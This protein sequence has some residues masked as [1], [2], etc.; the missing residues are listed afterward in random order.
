[1]VIISGMIFLAI[2]TPFIAAISFQKHRPTFGDSGRIAYAA[3]ISNLEF[4]FPGDGGDFY[5]DGIG[6][7]EN[8]ANYSAFSK[9]L[10]HPV[11][12]VFDDPAAYSFG[13]HTA[14]THPFWFD[15]SYWQEGVRPAFNLSRQLQV[16]GYAIA[17]LLVLT[18]GLFYQL[19]VTVILLLLF[20]LAP[21]PSTCLAAA[22]E[23][24][25]LLAP[26][27]I[28]ILMYA[29]VHLEYR[30]I[31]PF[32]CVG[33][34]VLFSGVR[35][36]FSNNLR[37]VMRFAVFFAA[38]SQ[39]VLAG[40]TTYNVLNRARHY[41]RYVDA[42]EA[43]RRQEVGPGTKIALISDDPLGQGGT[44]VA[45]LARTQVVAQVNDPMKFW[46]SPQVQPDVLEALAKAGAEV[47]LT[48]RENPKPKNWQQLDGSSYFI[49]RLTK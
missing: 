17:Y 23:V 9:Q 42:A 13:L 15:P 31:A 39:T 28:A 30:Y 25:Y 5:P 1:M 26:I 40:A 48:W 41:S 32:I 14:G 20:L 11:K 45:R 18:F 16:S 27:V 6:H 3:Y 33:W 4:L 29:I 38:L 21:R 46:S 49:K 2:A 43:L 10:T 47:A 36:P 35:L 34:I 24:W 22:A 19:A 37:F 12:R 8:I 7:A 44:F